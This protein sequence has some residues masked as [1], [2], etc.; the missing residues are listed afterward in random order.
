LGKE[1]RAPFPSVGEGPWDA[2]KNLT[3]GLGGE[4]KKKR[5][6]GKENK[7]ILFSGDLSENQVKETNSGRLK[8][9]A[10]IKKL[11]KGQG[12]EGAF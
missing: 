12:N 8:G 3:G 2:G 5:N 6:L 10:N 11:S 7:T 1:K 4:V 9:C